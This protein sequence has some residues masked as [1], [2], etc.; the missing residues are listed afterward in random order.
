MALNHCTGPVI[1]VPVAQHQPVAQHPAILVFM[2]VTQGAR[3][4]PAAVRDLP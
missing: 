2:P 4:L 3:S 1:H